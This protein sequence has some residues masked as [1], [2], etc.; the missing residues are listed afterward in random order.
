MNIIISQVIFGWLITGMFVDTIVTWLSL[1]KWRKRIAVASSWLS[2]WRATVSSEKISRSTQTTSC[3]LR[4]DAG[5][6]L[7]TT[8]MC[9]T[10]DSPSTR[11][12]SSSCSSCWCS[13]KLIIKPRPTKC[14]KRVTQNKDTRTKGHTQLETPNRLPINYDKKSICYM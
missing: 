4:Y 1:L 12:S 9:Q 14:R 11:C 3:R 8:A 2:S 13:S 7:R 10:A 6:L 5:Q